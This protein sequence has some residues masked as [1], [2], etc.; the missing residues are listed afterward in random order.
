MNLIHEKFANMLVS[1]VYVLRRQTRRVALRILAT[2]PPDIDG[3]PFK[4][5]RIVRMR[6]D[7]LFYKQVAG[8]Q[9]LAR[10]GLKAVAIGE[11]QPALRIITGDQFFDA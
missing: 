5:H 6:Q 3:L 9:A 11:Q 8:K 4:T 2:R 7:G 10:T 1:P